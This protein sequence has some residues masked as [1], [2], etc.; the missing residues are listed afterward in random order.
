MRH[1]RL[2]QALQ[3]QILMLRLRG[4][5]SALETPFIWSRC[6]PK[7]RGKPMNRHAHLARQ[8]FAP[9]LTCGN[10]RGPYAQSRATSR[11][12]QPKIWL[13]AEVLIRLSGHLNGILRRSQPRPRDQQRGK[14]ASF[15]PPSSSFSADTTDAGA[16]RD[17]ARQRVEISSAGLRAVPCGVCDDA[18]RPSRTRPMPRIGRSRLCRPTAAR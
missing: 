2:G 1:P 13:R 3:V 8:D 10:L 6:F 17:W 14:R 4:E 16:T 12:I 15:S 11:A 5:P 18:P 7:P 9:V